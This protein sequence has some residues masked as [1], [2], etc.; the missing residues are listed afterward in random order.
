[1]AG[2]TCDFV[3]IEKAMFQVSPSPA[4]SLSAFWA[5]QNA[6]PSGRESDVSKCCLALKT[7]FLLCGWPKMGLGRRL[8]SN[9]SNDSLTRRS[10]FLLS[11]PSNINLGASRESDFSRFR[12]PLR[13]DFLFEDDAKFY[14]GKVEEAMFQTDF[15]RQEV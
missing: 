1:M 2:T 11:G 6:T 3:E 4:N 9:V 7:D 13:T 8:E 15:L 10:H 14:L 12:M 5:A